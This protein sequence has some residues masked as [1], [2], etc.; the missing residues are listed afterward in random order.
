MMDLLPGEIGYVFMISVL[1]AALLSWLAL[2]WYRRSVFTLMRRRDSVPIDL[3]D[4]DASDV[5]S[6]APDSATLPA[7]LTFLMNDGPAPVGAAGTRSGWMLAAHRGR[8]VMAYGAGA[9]LYSLVVTIAMM[10]VAGAQRPIPAWF[11]VWWAHG[12]LIVPTLITVLV[13]ERTSAMALAAVYVVAGSVLVS[14][15]TLANQ[16]VHGRYNSAPL[17]NMYGIVELIGVTALFPLCLVML[18]AWRRI[19][20]VM[21]L[22]LAGTVLFGL[23]S[24]FF[25]QAL[26]D[27][28]NE[29]HFRT[30]LLDLS[31]AGSADITNYGLFMLVALPVGWMAWHVLQRIA[32]LF[33]RKR[34]SDVQLVVDCWWVTVA[35]AVIAS[36]LIVALGASGIAAGVAAFAVYRLSVAGVL[37]RVSARPARPTRLLLLRVFGYQARTE[38][39]F[40]GVAQRWRFRGPV[41]LIAGVD[42]AARTAD[43]GDMLALLGGRLPSQYIASDDQVLERV[44]RL[45]E[46]PDPDGRFRVNKLFCHDDT[47]RSTLQGLLDTSDVVLMDLRSFSA[48][49]AGCIFELEQLVSRVPTDRIVLVCD[50]STDLGLLE[51][52]LGNA[53]S[54]SRGDGRAR[55]S[56]TIALVRVDRQNQP[57]RRRLLASLVAAAPRAVRDEEVA[58]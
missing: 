33:A 21:P 24:I 56:G 52:T 49:N 58:V 11:A 22:A 3:H 51:D 13:L 10:A 43:P 53:W 6:S 45:D 23:A 8:V 47:W 7:Q 35:A 12:W 34:F 25:R 18:T 50:G 46:L 9:A 38:S 42:L 44:G 4:Q 19:R 17:T 28:F 54:R 32:G 26:I 48:Q 30:A 16:V 1:D 57:E 31:A 40:D 29:A 27:A 41:C 15:V 20:G 2:R 39:L 37:R 55:G 36:D 14:I 5:A